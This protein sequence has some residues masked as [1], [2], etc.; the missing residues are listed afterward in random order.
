MTRVGS[1]EI[2]HIAPHDKK[3]MDHEFFIRAARSSGAEGD[4]KGD[5]RQEY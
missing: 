2:K 4:A 5:D 1:I 3:A